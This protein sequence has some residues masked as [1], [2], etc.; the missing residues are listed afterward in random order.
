MKARRP[1]LLAAA[2]ERKDWEL[3]SYCL[4]LG[5]VEAARKLPPGALEQMLEAL[6]EAGSPVRRRRAGRRRADS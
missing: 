5:V 1:S 6:A 2:I 4:L 3:A